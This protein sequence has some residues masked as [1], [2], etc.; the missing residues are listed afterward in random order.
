MAKKSYY[1]GCHNDFYY[2]DNLDKY[3]FQE[4]REWVECPKCKGAG[5]IHGVTCPFCKGVGQIEQLPVNYK[6]DWERKVFIFCD[7]NPFVTKW[8]Y[9]PFAI[10]YF[11][12]SR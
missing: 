7:H 12:R 9:E 5:N 4:A 10:S 8:G 3:M 11:S 1:T 2:V 6:S